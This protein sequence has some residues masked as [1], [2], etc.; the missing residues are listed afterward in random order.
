[1]ENEQPIL[2][3]FLD[4]DIP[5]MSELGPSHIEWNMNIARKVKAGARHIRVKLIPDS[6]PTD[7]NKMGVAVYYPDQIT[8]GAEYFFMMRSDY[9]NIVKTIFSDGWQPN[10]FWLFDKQQ[11]IEQFY[12]DDFSYAGAQDMDINIVKKYI[13]LRDAVLSSDKLLTFDAYKKRFNLD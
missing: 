12:N 6:G 2:K 8:L 4:G 9:E 5:K 11:G 13:K 7:Y 3:R 10:D 1:M